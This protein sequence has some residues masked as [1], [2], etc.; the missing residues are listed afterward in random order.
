LAGK[1]RALVIRGLAGIAFGILTFIWPGIT[2]L[3]LVLLFGA[4]A[5]LDGVFSLGGAVRAMA[6]HERWGALILEG[7][8]GILAAVITIVWPGITAFG[9]VF[10]VAAWALVTGVLEMV[11]AI[12]LRRQISGEWLLL[13]GGIASVAF[14]ILLMIAPAAG[15][16]VIAL[17]MGAYA[18]IFGTLLVALGFRL[19]SWSRNALGRGPVPAHAH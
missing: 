14:G 13:L 3:S 15:A 9:L 16:L 6:S 18:L 12:R 11:A 17:W 19:R 4:Y 5:L 1:L 8:T 7:I 2:V 10:L